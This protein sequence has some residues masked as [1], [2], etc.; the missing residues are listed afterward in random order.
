MQ[1]AVLFSGF[2]LI[3]VSVQ[4][5]TAAA[6]EPSQPTIAEILR[7]VQ[8]TITNVSG[9]IDN[10]VASNSLSTDALTKL[11]SKLASPGDTCAIDNLQL[12]FLQN[13]ISNALKCPV[14]QI[15]TGEANQNPPILPRSCKDIASKWPNASNGFY[16]IVNAHGASVNVYC[17]FQQLC[18]AKNGWTR[19]AFLNMTD[20]SENCPT[21]FKLYKHG[22]IRACGKYSS[23]CLHK[24]FSTHNI[25]YNKVC[26]R[27]KGYQ[28]GSPDGVRPSSDPGFDGVS[29]TYGNPRKHLWAFTADNQRGRLL[30]PC[31]QNSPYSAPAYIGS[32]YYCD[33]GNSHSWRP[34]LYTEPLWQGPGEHVIQS[35][36]AC[37]Q[38]P[39]LPW[40]YRNLGSP[41]TETMELRLCLDQKVSD[42]DMPI[43]E[44]EIF[45][46]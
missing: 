18:G 44:Y 26:G 20:P 24:T 2:V 3:Q 40:F 21:G 41:V 25:P 35:D 9:L 1:I 23:G 19:V 22:L 14:N 17:Y 8:Y 42:E 30:C 45:I 36:R 16:T 10:V 15:C 39:H 46:A 37:Y 13:N 31:A 34:T 12:Q 38:N 29:I 33:S 43:D 11:I 32:N 28:F 6:Q 7:M 5:T 4:G 27:V